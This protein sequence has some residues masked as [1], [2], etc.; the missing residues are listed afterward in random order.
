[1]N[2]KWRWMMIIPPMSRERWDISWDWLG[3][4]I[5]GSLS[6]TFPWISAL[7]RSSWGRELDL[8]IELLLPAIWY[9]SSLLCPLLLFVLPPQLSFLTPTPFNFSQGQLQSLWH[10]SPTHP[11]APLCTNYSSVW[12]S[13][14]IAQWKY[15]YAIFFTGSISYFC[16]FSQFSRNNQG[17]H[18]VSC[19][20]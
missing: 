13:N 18:H 20:C 10:F 15:L 8:W 14:W 1:M 11:P 19:Y 12:T 9:L 2:E 6:S 3:N 16:L 4:K 17:Q 7:L 5:V